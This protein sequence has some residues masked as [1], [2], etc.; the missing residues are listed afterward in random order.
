MAKKVLRNVRIYWGPLAL[1]SNVNALQLDATASEVDVTTFDSGVWGESL[2]GLVKATARLDGY[3]TPD[4]DAV[5]FDEL[6]GSSLPATVTIPAAT[7]PA[8]GEVAFFLLASESSYAV[9]GAVGTA[10][11]LNLA[12]SGGSAVHRGA[13]SDYAAAAD[14]SGNGT[15][16][17]LG[18]VTAGQRLYYAVHVFSAAGTSPTLDLVIQSETDDL[19][20]SPTARVTV[21]QFTAAGSAYG[22]IAGPVTDTWWRVARTVG[23]T[24]PEFGYVVALAIH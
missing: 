24:D 6:G 8:A 21:P 14:A 11:R 3:W 20:A 4:P 2:V 15:G 18:A 23:G 10:A 7:D 16:L 22:S 9:G 12:L 13:V 5:T 17:E 1:A 19:W